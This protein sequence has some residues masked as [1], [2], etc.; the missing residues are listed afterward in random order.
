LM[1]SSGMSTMD[2]IE[3]AIAT[4]G[5][6]DLM[7]AHST[8]AYPCNVEELNLKMIYPLQAKYPEAVIGYS[9]HEVGLATT[10][11]AVTMGAAF[12][13][14]HITLDRSMWGSDQAASVEIM[15]MH[16]LVRDIRSIE[17]AMGDGVKRVY[18]SEKGALKKLRRVNDFNKSNE[19]VNS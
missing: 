19:W 14:R 2:Q 7:I 4:I 13:E 8:S 17:K 9:G 12:V 10:L 18:D 5:S 1:I 16:R 3:G 6:E 15:G 11:A